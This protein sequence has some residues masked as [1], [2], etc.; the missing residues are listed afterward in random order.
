MSAV[1][2]KFYKNQGDKT[3]HKQPDGS[4]VSTQNDGGSLGSG[5]THASYSTTSSNVSQHSEDREDDHDEIEEGEWGEMESAQPP[6]AQRTNMQSSGPSVV[7]QKDA[8]GWDDDDDDWDTFNDEKAKPKAPE[9]RKPIVPAANSSDLPMPSLSKLSMK[10]SQPAA[11]SPTPAKQ[12]DSWN[13]GADDWSST[14]FTP[15]GTVGD[16]DK[17]SRMEEAKRKREERK[18]QRLQEIEAK[19]ANKSGPMKL[20]TQKDNVMWDA[21][22]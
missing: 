11:V 7:A 20:G 9:I 18:L 14:K 2:S 6:S 3:S 1:T 4:S 16:S 5:R 13:D 12:A 15:V 22:E 21:L 8:D 10:P 17:A 19:R